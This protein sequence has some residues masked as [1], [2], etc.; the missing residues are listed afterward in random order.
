MLLIFLDL[1]L[2]KI[3]FVLFYKRLFVGPRFGV[4]CNIMMAAITAWTVAQFVVSSIA[5]SSSTVLDTHVR[6][7][8][9]SIPGTFLDSGMTNF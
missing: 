8:K 5:H 3:S 7:F 6:R 2:I 1:G 4:V 9:P